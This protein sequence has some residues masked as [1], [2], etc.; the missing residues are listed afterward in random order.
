M[1]SPDL[2]RGFGRKGVKM[3]REGELEDLIARWTLDEEEFALLAN[4]TGATRLGF[5]V[6]LKYLGVGEDS[7]SGWR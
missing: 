5:V 6:L 3:R 4:K 2:V 1:F 7:C